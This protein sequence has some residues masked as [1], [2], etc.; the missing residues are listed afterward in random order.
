V[1]SFSRGRARQLIVVNF[2]RGNLP[3][4]DLFLQQQGID[5]TTPGGIC[6]R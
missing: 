2:K 3:K 5:T 1:T 6:S 4:D